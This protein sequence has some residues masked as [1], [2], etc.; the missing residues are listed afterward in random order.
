LPKTDRFLLP[1]SDMLF[2]ISVFGNKRIAVFGYKFRRKKYKLNIAENRPNFIAVFGNRLCY[3]FFIF[4]S[5]FGSI[6]ISVFGYIF[7]LLNLF[8]F[9][10]SNILM[11]PFL[12]IWKTREIKFLNIF[13]SEFGYIHDIRFRQYIRFRQHRRLPK[14][15][16][17]GLVVKGGWMHKC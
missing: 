1:F 5:I 2:N 17:V 13:I 7:F 16:R 15:D 4:I 9:P 14:T 6:W 11:L 3:F 12:A 10:I 8:L